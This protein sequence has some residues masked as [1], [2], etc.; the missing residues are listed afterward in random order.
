MTSTASFTTFLIQ[1]VTVA[2]VRFQCANGVKR[3]PR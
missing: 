3:I 1:K 2:I